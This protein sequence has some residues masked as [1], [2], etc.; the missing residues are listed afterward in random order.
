MAALSGLG[1]TASHAAPPS[2]SICQR[3]APS[4]STV[5]EMARA[6]LCSA[7]LMLC[8]AWAA[9]RYRITDSGAGSSCVSLRA[10]AAGIRVQASAATVCA[11]SSVSIH[12][13][14]VWLRASARRRTVQAIATSAL[15]CC[16]PV[17]CAH[18]ARAVLVL[19]FVMVCFLLDFL[20]HSGYTQGG[21]GKAPRSPFGVGL[22][23]ALVG[24]PQ[25]LFYSALAALIIW[26]ASSGVVAVVS[27]SRASV[28]R[29]ALNSA[30]VI[31]SGISSLPFKR[32]S[33]FFP[34]PYI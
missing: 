5:A 26:A 13:A 25:A 27:T 6:C 31:P 22:R 1:A 11:S 24:D 32:G 2:V 23:C 12:A 19:I 33:R 7:L 29:N 21:G 30:F 28:S 9:A 18:S 10:R 20:S 16:S 17:I 15:Y 3:S 14:P 8:A 4:S 34:L